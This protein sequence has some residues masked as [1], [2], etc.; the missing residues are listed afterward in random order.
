MSL[1]GTNT[2]VIGVNLTDT[3]LTRITTLASGTITVGDSGQTGDITFSTAT[4]AT[5]AG[6]ATTALQSTAGA[7]KIVLDNGTGTGTALN[8]NS[9]NVSLTAVAGGIV[10][11]ATN[12][13][14]ATDIGSATNTALVSAGAIGINSL[15]VQIGAT[16]LD[17]NTSANNSNQFLNATGAVTI[18]ATGL[19]AGAAT[20]EL[21]GG[22]FTLGGSNRIND[23][24]KLNVNGGTFAIG[25][26]SETV[27][28]VTLTSGSITGSSGVLTSTNT[29][30]TKS[31]SASAILAGSNGLTQST[32]GTTTLSGANTFTSTTT[33]SGGKL[34]FSNQTVPTANI[35]IS[36]GAT[37]EYAISSGSPVQSTTTLTGTG[38]LLKT[39]AGSLFFGGASTGNINWQLGAGAL[40]DVQGGLLVGG[41]FVKDVWTSNL[42]DLNIAS[43]ASFAGV[44]ANVNIDRLTGGGTLYTSYAGAGYIAFNLGVNGGSS[45]FSGAIVNDPPAVGGGAGVSNINKMGSG[46]ITLSG[47]NTYS[48][49]TTI[50]GGTLALSGA[51]TNNIASTTTIDVQT[52]TILDVTGLTSGTLVLAS[53]Q[54]LKGKGTV[55]GKTTAPSGS[56]VSPGEGPASSTPATSPST[57]APTSTSHSTAPPSA[58]NT[59][60]TTSPA[61]VTV[62]GGNLVVSLGYTPANGDAFTII[63]NTTSNALTLTN[64][65]QVA[66]TSIPEGGAFTVGGVR[67]LITYAGGANHNDVVLTVQN[68]TTQLSLSSGN[69]VV[70]DITAGGQNDNLTIKADTTNGNF[71]ISDPSHPL[72]IAGTI[73]GATVSSDLH[74]V[75]V[76][77][78]S[79]TGSQIQVNTL[80]GND[81]LTVDTS[82]GSFGVPGKTIIYDGGASATCC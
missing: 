68:F 63:N 32:G 30:Q 77:F 2:A 65:F 34:T 72:G 9:G 70:A 13:T 40:I 3:E 44:E 76:P 79:V 24:T 31:G 27:N 51:F 14:A 45:T 19:T 38:T 18:D 16:N 60:R 28:T 17:A 55:S 23:S 37:L 47:S 48:G 59:T 62:N 43:G 29:I 22:A 12:T 41:N 54:T 35:S 46:T 7:D 82:L 33:V 21:D 74:T 53:G 57:A 50:S 5:T 36:T 1:G 73:T 11:A 56:T 52:G 81:T 71:L 6:A 25:T 80:G 75:T 26:F 67:F 69:L 10:E 15:P 8:G 20:V 42:S 4:V 66:G 39:G 64:P 58:R 78:A 61:T 49:T